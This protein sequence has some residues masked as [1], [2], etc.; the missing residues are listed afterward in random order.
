MWQTCPE[1]K[2]SAF[3]LHSLPIWQA[4]LL[5]L[6]RPWCEEHRRSFECPGRILRHH[7]LIDSLW[8][9]HSFLLCASMSAA[10]PIA[11]TAGV[12]SSKWKSKVVWSEHAGTYRC[13]SRCR[14]CDLAGKL[15]DHKCPGVVVKQRQNNSLATT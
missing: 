2:T 9:K 11:I 14:C 6:W 1:E 3:L 15:S 7:H 13:C 10:K 4:A 8:I 12:I 5:G